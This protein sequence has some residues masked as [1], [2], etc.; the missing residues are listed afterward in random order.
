MDH[1]C[2]SHTAHPILELYRGNTFFKVKNSWREWP[3]SDLHTGKL[4][5]F[6]SRL[7]LCLHSSF[8]YPVH[9]RMYRC[10]CYN[11]DS[12]IRWTWYDSN[13]FFGSARAYGILGCLWSQLEISAYLESAAT[14]RDPMRC[15]TYIRASGGTKLTKFSSFEAAALACLMSCTKFS[16]KFSTSCTDV[17]YPW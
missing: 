11:Y 13:N 10:T 6:W 15:A 5:K 7:P 12:T 3:P 9:V 14:S 2:F 8:I 16:T 17:L 1:P 4:V